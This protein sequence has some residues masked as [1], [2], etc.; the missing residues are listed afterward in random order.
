MILLRCCEHL[1]RYCLWDL[2]TVTRAK[3]VFD[4]GSVMGVSICKLYGKL[5]LSHKFIFPSQDLRPSRDRV[6]S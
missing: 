3:Q 1:I 2:S 6:P 5:P 4:K